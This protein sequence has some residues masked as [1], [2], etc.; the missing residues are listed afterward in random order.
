M[1][2]SKNLVSKPFLAL[3]LCAFF[4]AGCVGAGNF[5]WLDENGNGIQDGGEPGVSNV[6][7]TLFNSAD[8][9]AIASTTTDPAGMYQ[10][11]QQGVTSGT[12]Y[13]G[14][15]LPAGFDFTLQDQGSDDDV[16]S[17]ADP[18]TGLTAA[19]SLSAVVEHVDAGL[20]QNSSLEEEPDS[21]AE[22]T[23]AASIGDFV[24]QDLNSDGI[25][26]AG[27][28]GVAGVAVSL[29]DADGNEVDNT[30]TDAGGLYVFEDQ[31]VGEDYSIAFALPAG[32]TFTLQ[33]QGSDDALDSDADPVSGE[34]AEFSL[35]E[36]GAQSLDVGLVA[37]EVEVGPLGPDEFPT[38]YNP[39]TGQPLCD[40]EAANWGVVGISIS[41]FPPQATRPPTGLQWAAW[42]TEWWIGQGDTR[43]YVLYYG[44]YPE[45]DLAAALGDQQGEGA[46]TL[47]EGEYLISDFV[48]YDTN[49]NAVQDE[50]EPGV[51]TVQ[52]ELILNSEVIATTTTD[53][54]GKYYFVV[55]PEFGFRYQVRFI[56]PPGLSTFNFVSQNL[57][58]EDVDSDADPFTGLTDGFTLPEDVNAVDFVD[59]GLSHSIRIEGVRSGRIVYEVIRQFFEGCTVIAGADPEV[60]AQMQICALAQTS[61]P[62]DIGAAGLDVGKL[63]E[64]A[65]NNV[66]IYGPPN[67]TGNLFDPNPP[68][69]CAPAQSLTMFYNINNQTYWSYDEATGAYLRHQNTYL[70]PETQEVS[71][72][73]L[74]GQ[75]LYFENVI[76][77][78]TEHEQLNDAGTIFDVNMESTIGRAKLLRDGLACDM[79][80]S[81]INGPYEQETGRTRPIRF[82]YADGSPFPL[83]PGKLFI[84]MVHT[85]ADFFEPEPGSGNWRARWYV[86]Q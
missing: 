9:N 55:E 47:E 85:N 20:V 60:L 52:V 71:T 59:A 78:F 12:Y 13:V 79:F 86:P 67:L 1:I 38:G 42:V 54:A 45:Q 34:T 62:G 51:P 46:P 21:S 23:S 69:S 7:V 28:P 58:A 11:V 3:S 83:K 48:W 74:T 14:F 19:Y 40:P 25:Q 6:D 61:D 63:K 35:A 15:N 31:L 24:W 76:V 82:V 30:T 10:L 49:G 65:A 43:L 22:P 36:G 5:V 72:E 39:L 53:G 50:G 84:H 32:F 70:D 27:E 57:G 37:E 77:F 2:A 68:E 16:D 18:S 44:C 73:A 33:D 75:P 80:W 56:L 66:G 26:N 4:L 29:R 17:D 64:I 81:T 41:Q 8:D